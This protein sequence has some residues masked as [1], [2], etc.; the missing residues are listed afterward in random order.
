MIDT[1]FQVKIDILPDKLSQH[2]S[3]IGILPIILICG[4]IT[5]CDRTQ[6]QDNL[7]LKKHHTSTGFTNIE[8]ENPHHGFKDFLKWQMN[9]PDT[10]PKYNDV[11]GT[12]PIVNPDFSHYNS[13]DSFFSTTWLG[14][15]TL[16]LHM[17]GKT[18]ITDPIFSERCSPFQWAGP[19]R[20]TPF[21]ISQDIL[22]TID[23]VLISH[24][25]YDHLDKSTV[26]KLG[27]SPKWL[28]P[29][30]LKA[31]F[32]SLGITNVVELD[33]WDEFQFDGFTFACTPT[34][35]FSGR[36]F[37]DRFKTL[38]CS[39]A[40]LG[41]RARFWFAGDTGYFS[42]FRTIG[43]KYGPF[44][45]SAIPIGAYE[46]RWFMNP[47]HVTP[48]QAV[49]IHQD[50]HSRQSIGIHWGTFILTDEPI[51]EPLVL[52]QEAIDKH[53]LSPKEF[54][55]LKHGETRTFPI[56]DKSADSVNE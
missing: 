20:F 33:W 51:T 31:W 13:D 19:K 26:L 8:I 2:A 9:K 28:V 44:D 45:L 56:Y 25:H 34:Q 42:R 3:L 11:T 21:P 36:G 18:I 29:L 46:P 47:M 32:E 1:F 37:G 41:K 14:H 38:W 54:V 10:R 27:N 55:T 5:S 49:M 35:H 6:I 23:V 40:V 15:A 7:P 17:E 53:H 4:M 12:F 43:E 39:W 52:L 48:D 30:G 16:L 50:I 22:P 24:N